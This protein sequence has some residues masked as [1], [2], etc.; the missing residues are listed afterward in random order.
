ML[1]NRELFIVSYLR[2]ISPT[3]F[4]STS[5]TFAPGVVELSFLV[6]VHPDGVPEES[7]FF[8]L[9]LE[10]PWGGAR[11][12]A[13]HRTRVTVVDADGNGTTT[14]Y[15]KTTASE[16]GDLTDGSKDSSSSFG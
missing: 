9:S 2:S 1:E 4:A 11:L 5:L 7:E 8:D 3:P 15:A 10:G 6:G 12:G 16:Y 13:Q 14:D